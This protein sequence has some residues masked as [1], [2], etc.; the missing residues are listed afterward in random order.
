MVEA[1]TEQATVPSLGNIFGDEVPDNGAS[2]DKPSSS[3][4]GEQETPSLKD[5]KATEDK[6]ETKEEES[7]EEDPKESK[8]TSSKDSE[9][10]EPEEKT[11]ES[12]FDWDSDENPLKKEK[13]RL[14]KQLKDTRNYATRVNQENLQLK[15]EYGVETEL[16]IEQETAQKESQIAFDNRERA[17]YQIAVDKYGEDYI[18]ENI[19]GEDGLFLKLVKDD[20]ATYSRVFNSD[21]PVIEA[22]QVVK[23]VKFF[24]KYGR[25]LDKISDKIR[26]EIEPVLRKE[27]T[28]ELQDKLKLKDKELTTLSGVEGSAE[29]KESMPKI[30][31]KPLGALFDQ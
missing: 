10:G 2:N 9:D 15:K 4:E 7:K 31:N 14:E 20:P 12:S 25:D 3:E 27:I 13:I 1:V 5:D 16:S 28:K 19:Y 17:S 29:T 23:E 11:E 6:I 30:F 22:V 21:L 26:A 8:E 24:E 18:S